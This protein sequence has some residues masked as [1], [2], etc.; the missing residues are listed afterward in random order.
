MQTDRADAHAGTA[1][2]TRAGEMHDRIGERGRKRLSVQVANR[3][4]LRNR[5]AGAQALLAT[6]AGVKLLRD[7]VTRE[8][9]D[10]C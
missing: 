8:A 4:W 6:D 2:R 1:L 3:N 5:R 9:T 7:I 10:K